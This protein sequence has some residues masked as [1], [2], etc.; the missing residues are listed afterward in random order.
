MVDY[1]EIIDG[2]G[3]NF[4]HFTFDDGDL[5]RTNI[6]SNTETVDVLFHTDGSV[7]RRGWRLEW[8]KYKK[9]R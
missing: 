9:Q 5:T 7:T 8:S 2:D 6:T 3:T 1:V 4:G